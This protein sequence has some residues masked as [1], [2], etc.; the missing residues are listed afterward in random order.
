MLMYLLGRAVHYWYGVVR[1]V[2]WADAKLAWN[3][4]ELYDEPVEDSSV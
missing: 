2:S 1:D 3:S 4:V